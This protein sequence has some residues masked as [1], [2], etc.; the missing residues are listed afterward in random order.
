MTAAV[1]GAGIRSTLMLTDFPR[2]CFPRK[3]ANGRRKER[4]APHWYQLFAWNWSE[5]ALVLCV[6]SLSVGFCPLHET[7]CFG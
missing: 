6:E 1:V 5:C 4:V 2:P 7:E 3:A